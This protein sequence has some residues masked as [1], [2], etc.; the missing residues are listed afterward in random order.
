MTSSSLDNFHVCA[1]VAARQHAERQTPG[2]THLLLEPEPLHPHTR[3]CTPPPTRPLSS[4]PAGWGGRSF[5]L[6]VAFSLLT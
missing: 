6:H 3:L 2:L 5:V 4:G 1:T